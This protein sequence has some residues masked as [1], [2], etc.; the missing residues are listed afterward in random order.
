MNKNYRNELNEQMSEK[1]K[2]NLLINENKE[3]D[4]KE[5]DFLSKQINDEKIINEKKKWEKINLYKAQLDKQIQS[6]KEQNDDY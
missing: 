4:K 6:K 3:N 5:R 1:K 2:E